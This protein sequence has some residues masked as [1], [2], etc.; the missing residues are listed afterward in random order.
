MAADG[1]TTYAVDHQVSKL[2]F[3]EGNR[4]IVRHDMDIS[5]I[6]IDGTIA[7]EG[8][9]AVDLGGKW[10]SKTLTVDLSAH[11]AGVFARNVGDAE[12]NVTAYPGDGYSASKQ[13]DDLVLI[14][15]ESEKKSDNIVWIA[16]GAVILALIV[17]GAV[18]YR[19]KRP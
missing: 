12:W 2:V 6:M 1:K 4:L 18:L 13:G 11:K 5:M 8:S 9:Y 3:T 10:N 14:G 15:P 19:L 7:I 17:G 16:V